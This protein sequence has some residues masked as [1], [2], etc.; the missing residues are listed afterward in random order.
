MLPA[1][2]PSPPASSSRPVGAH[3]GDVHGAV[4]CQVCGCACHDDDAIV[5][6]REETVVVALCYGCTGQNDIVLRSTE[7]G[8]EVHARPRPGR[9]A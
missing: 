7:R 8:I 1:P 6:R 2:I 5:V 3:Q 4:P 9:A